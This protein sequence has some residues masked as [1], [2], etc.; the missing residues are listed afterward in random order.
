MIS[1]L[2]SRIAHC[3][4]HVPELFVQWYYFLVNEHEK[5]DKYVEVG[6]CYLYI[7]ALIFYYL[8]LNR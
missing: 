8:E 6:Q 7:N 4:R 3:Y 2:C 1:E 5:R